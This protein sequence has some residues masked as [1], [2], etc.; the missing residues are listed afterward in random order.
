M[1]Q[2][3]G[4]NLVGGDSW[5]WNVALEDYDLGSLEGAALKYFFRGP[6]ADQKL[7]LTATLQAD[8]TF[9]FTAAGADTL[10]LVGTCS[11]SLCFFDADSNRTEL[12]RGS[13]NVLADVESAATLDGRSWAKRMYD[14]VC[15]V[16]ENRASRVEQQYQIG[17]RQVGLLSPDELLKLKTNLRAQVNRELIDSGQRDPD[18]NQIKAAF[19]PRRTGTGVW[20]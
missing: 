11:W 8:G 17:G 4:E 18:S 5:N 20:R 12:A 2:P 15:A 7:D 16:L 14:A 6:S 10:K 3:F 9:Q 19:G 13:V 1:R